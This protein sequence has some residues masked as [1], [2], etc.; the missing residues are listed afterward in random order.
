MVK[1]LAKGVRSMHFI[2]YM[3]VFWQDVWCSVVF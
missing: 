3:C 1:R 2:L